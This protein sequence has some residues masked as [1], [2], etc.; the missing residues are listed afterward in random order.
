MD[1][2]QSWLRLNEEKRGTV[3]RNV[4]MPE[5]RKQFVSIY[6]LRVE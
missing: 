4:R 5:N 3:S 1:W 6:G 2:E